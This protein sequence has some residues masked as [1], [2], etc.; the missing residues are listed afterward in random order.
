MD[1]SGV[2]QRGGDADQAVVRP[3]GQGDVAAAGLGAVRRRAAP[4]VGD[5]DG[6]ED[7]GG[8]SGRVGG[9]TTCGQGQGGGR[10]TGQGEQGFHRGVPF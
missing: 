5:R 2:G 4:G 3:G 1:L 9:L 10:Q 6:S 8:V 7:G